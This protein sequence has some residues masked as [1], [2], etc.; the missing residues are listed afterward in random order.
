MTPILLALL[1][2]RPSPA[3]AD[4]I[5][6]VSRAYAALHSYTQLT[7]T[8]AH[9]QVGGQATTTTYRS[10]L[11]VRRPDR[12]FLEVTSPAIG[13]LLASNDGEALRIYASRTRQIWTM[14]PVRTVH[15]F[16]AALSR[17]QMAFECDPISFLCGRAPALSAVSARQITV[18]G[19]S[20]TMLTGTLASEVT[21]PGVRGRASL[22][23]DTSTQLIRRVELAFTAIPVR[24]GVAGGS[25]IAANTITVRV[26]SLRANPAL[27]ESS[28]VFA[29][30]RGAIRAATPPR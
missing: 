30:P 15:A 6:R 17:H 20:G 2:L 16:F 29:T 8:E 18:E 4:E 19:I 10:T 21:W 27:A 13:A 23:V 11:R 5:G 26:R 25:L 14:P 3:A 22:L 28:F 7:E 9:G 24:S 1:L 12:V